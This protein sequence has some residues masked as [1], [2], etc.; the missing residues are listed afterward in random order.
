MAFESVPISN[1]IK[2]YS[3]VDRLVVDIRSMSVRDV[4]KNSKYFLKNCYIEP[5]QYVL[6]TENIFPLDFNDDSI[7]SNKKKRT[8]EDYDKLVTHPD[9]VIR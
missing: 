4:E 3:Q 2:V 1:F 5:I 7:R 6:K 8:F 9:K